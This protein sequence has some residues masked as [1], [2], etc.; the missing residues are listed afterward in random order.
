MLTRTTLRSGPVSIVDCRCAAGPADPSFAERHAIH[1]IA[2][3]RKGSFGYRTRGRAFELVAGSILLGHPGD[4]YQCTHHHHAGGDECLSF[5]FA[6]EWIEAIGADPDVARVGGVPPVAELMMLGALAQAAVDGH[7]DVGLDEIGLQFAKR[8]IDVVSDEPPRS[9]IARPGDRRRMVEAA[10]W[11][12]AHSHESPDLDTIARRF[13]R[14]PF[15]FLRVFSAVVGVTP[16]QYL[17]RSRLRCAAR[18]LLD[19]E[20]SVTDVA[21]DVGFGDVSHFVRT[22]RRATGL[23][24]TRFRRAA[25]RSAGFPRRNS[26]EEHHA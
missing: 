25:R 4:E 1:C 19:A 8:V 7:A 15:H 16:H 9:V 12:E 21:Y 20:R 5:R 10:L 11:L 18:L 17:I 14:S 23:S 24:P 3:V 22:F 6:P 13:D 2:Y 26:R